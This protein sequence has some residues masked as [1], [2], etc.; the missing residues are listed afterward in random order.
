MGNISN[1]SFLAS[2]L[3]NMDLYMDLDLY[4]YLPSVL[5][6]YL[7]LDYT[8]HQ[9][10]CG[11][12]T[13]IVLA[14]SFV[15]VLGLGLYLPSFFPMVLVLGLYLPSILSQYLYL[16]LNLPSIFLRYLYLYL[17]LPSN[18]P[19]TEYLYLPSRTC[20]QPCLTVHF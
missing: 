9:F 10:C 8:C 7:D 17:Y 11:T 1:Q 14:I 12:W 6:R 2:V 5:L 3:A 16:Y 19:V 15:A 13:W 4:L 18:F 20:T